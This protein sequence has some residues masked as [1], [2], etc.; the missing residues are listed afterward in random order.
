MFY[1]YS[2]YTI[3][4]VN[5]KLFKWN[6]S[7]IFVGSLCQ[8][9]QNLNNHDKTYNQSSCK[10]LVINIVTIYI[11]CCRQEEIILK[12]V[13]SK[14]LDRMIKT[15]K[16]FWIKVHWIFLNISLICVQ[17]VLLKILAW[18]ALWLINHVVLC[19]TSTFQAHISILHI[20]SFWLYD[21]K[22]VTLLI[23]QL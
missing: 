2:I 9:K 5:Q 16:V 8:N 4:N 23:L 7:I 18:G 17:N 10:Q 20:P 19:V 11:D 3:S 22:H 21:I 1:W 12:N 14:N 13:Y 6:N 15:L